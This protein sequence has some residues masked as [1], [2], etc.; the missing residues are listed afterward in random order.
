MS[1]DRFLHSTL[2]AAAGLMAGLC[3]LCTLT[4]I[5]W[6]TPPILNKASDAPYAWMFLIP[7]LLIG[8]LG[9]LLGGALFHSA[10]SRP[11]KP[12][13]LDLVASGLTAISAG[14]YVLVFAGLTALTASSIWI[15][16]SAP[17]EMGSDIV[18]SL[19]LS[20]VFAVA[21]FGCLQL[22]WDGWSRYRDARE[23]LAD[24]QNE[25]AP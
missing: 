5:G 19:V 2:V 22:A 11:R 23:S 3:G 7:S 9:M 20:I 24:A 10:R 1:P 15:Q 16:A 13:S 14:L 12:D 8:G 25:P 17:R 6:T 21:A 18:F 4:V